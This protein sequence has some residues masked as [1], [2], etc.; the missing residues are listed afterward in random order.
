[1][2]EPPL[3]VDTVGQADPLQPIQQILQR[4]YDGLQL[5]L[6]GVGEMS[7]MMTTSRERLLQEG[8]SWPQAHGLTLLVIAAGGL[9]AALVLYA[10]GALVHR[11]LAR[12]D[13]LGR[14]GRS[15]RQL[16]VDLVGM[17]AFATTAHL[18]LFRITE[19]GSYMQ[20]WIR[21]MLFAAI[22]ALAYAILGRLLFAPRDPR[23]RLVDIAR[24]GW[25][26]TML[27]LYGAIGGVVAQSVRLAYANGADP[28][29]IEGWFFVGTTILTV[30]KLWWFIGGA[31]DMR[32]AFAGPAPGTL[33]RVA[34]A[35]LPAFYIVSAIFIW[36][37][38]GLATGTPQSRAWVFAAGAT[39]I[40][41]LALPILA[42]GTYGLIDSAIDRRNALAPRPPLEKAIQHGL[43]ALLTGGVWLAGSYVALKLWQPILSDNAGMT[44]LR[45]I[46]IGERVMLAIVLAFAFWSFLRTFFEGVVPAK[47]PLLP[48]AEDTD[49]APVV[50]SRLST[51]LPLVRNFAFAGTLALLSL[52]VLSSLGVDIGPLI[53]GFGILGL[54]F[55]FGSQTLVKDIV[56][57][58]FFIADDAFR[59]GEYVDTGKLKGTVEH[60]SIRSLQLRHQ[61]G[62]LHTIPFGQIQ[63]ITNYSRDWSTI[64]FELRFDRDAD[65][66]RIRKTIK[67]VGLELMED[68]EVGKEFLVPLKMQGIQDITDNSL[69]IRLKFTAKPGNPS[70]IQ[71][72]AMKRLLA[73]FKVAGIALSSNAVTVRGGAEHGP[74]AAAAA[75]VGVAKETVAPAAG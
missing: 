51:V 28:L 42:L 13:T 37:A 71:R 19:Q 16:A 20:G 27:T 25:H 10:L 18:V 53:A 75:S 63:S 4:L 36:L 74:L 67:K 8:N 49:A 43:Q 45:M 5:A 72:E 44:A 61:N 69:V 41:A 55:S 50:A 39:Q 17:A 32:V 46:A 7:G 1:M 33:R 70:L 48:G 31:R 35:L 14:L 23:A 40:I 11:R 30:Q 56:S 57:G 26:W 15:L 21:A 62:P 66:E 54:A 6:R 73:A 9:A 60:I 64:K 52:I 34:A 29:A 22:T 12:D 59:V 2:S 38:G 24:P 58:M 68:G 47:R 3:P 65:P